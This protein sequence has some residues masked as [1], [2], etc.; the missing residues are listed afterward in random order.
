MGPPPLYHVNILD[1][2]LAVLHLNT[3][4]ITR[5]WSLDKALCK[6]FP[7]S[8]QRPAPTK[9]HDPGEPDYHAVITAR[10]LLN[11]SAR[12]RILTGVSNLM[13]NYRYT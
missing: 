11:L 13:L 9:W 10:T 3:G 4:L 7:G 6:G 12:A 1:I 2:F 8:L 5:H